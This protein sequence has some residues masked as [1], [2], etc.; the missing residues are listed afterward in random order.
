MSGTLILSGT[1]IQNAICIMFQQPI[2]IC[3]NTLIEEK[4]RSYI[5]I[6]QE[7]KVKRIKIKNK[8]F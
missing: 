2:I 6:Y 1:L 3:Y 8:N 5:A 4:K 7:M